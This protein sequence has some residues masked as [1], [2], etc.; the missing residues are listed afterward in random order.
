[1]PG[2][3]RGGKEAVRQI[4]RNE[5]VY[6]LA[7]EGH[8]YFDFQRWYAHDPSFDISTLN[9]QILGYKGSPVGA[10]AG[11]RAFTARNWYYAVP[12]AEID[13]NPALTQGDGWGN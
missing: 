7:G 8:L 10:K 11:T 3:K 6:E 13:I 2:V 4:I 1:M 5:R 9:H 12:Q